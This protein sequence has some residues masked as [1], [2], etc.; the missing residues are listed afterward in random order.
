MKKGKSDKVVSENV[1]EFHK[2]KT[3]A[4]TEKKFGKEKADKQAIAVAM[5]EKRKSK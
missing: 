1:S 2:G 4:K 3:F 5:K